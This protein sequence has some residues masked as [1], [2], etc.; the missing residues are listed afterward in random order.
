MTATFAVSLTGNATIRVIVGPC[1]DLTR[2]TRASVP[3]ATVNGRATVTVAGLVA[4]FTYSY[5]I[6]IN[7][8]LGVVAGTFVCPDTS[9]RMVVAFGGDALSGSASPVF[10]AICAEAPDLFI[11]LGDMHYQ[12]I[13]VADASQYDAAWDQVLASSTQGPFCRSVPMLYCWDDHDYG[14]DNADGTAI[15]RDVACQVYRRRVPHPPLVETTDTG[16]IYHA[17]EYTVGGRGVVFLVTDERSRATPNSAADT[18]SKSMLGTAQ[19]AWFKAVLADPANAGKLFVWCCSRVFGAVAGNGPDTWGSFTTERTELADWI[20][21][22]A[23]GRVLVLSADMHALAVDDG[24]HHDFATGGGCPLPCFQAAP[25]DHTLID[26]SPYG[27]GTYSHGYFAANRQY[28]LM[29]LTAT[30]AGFDVTWTGKRDGAVLVTRTWSV[31]L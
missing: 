20:K 1:A 27:G 14:T 5:A 9:S 25:L 2:N 4:G 29:T 3:V 21:A 17:V 31:A 22:H 19:K 30:G 16:A 7:G 28:G 11:H 12:N 24:S 15:S 23:L 10:D 13:A 8:V 26:T 18:A 6:E